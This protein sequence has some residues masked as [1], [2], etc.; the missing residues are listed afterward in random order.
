ME[1]TRKEKLKELKLQIASIIARKEE[2]IRKYKQQNKQA[3]KVLKAL[4]EDDIT[5]SDLN[6]K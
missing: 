6:N 3:E 1:E 4:F 2:E 5:E